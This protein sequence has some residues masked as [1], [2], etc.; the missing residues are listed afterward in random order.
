M[1][2]RADFNVPIK[3][4]RVIDDYKIQRGLPTIQYLIQKGAKVILVSHLGRPLSFPKGTQELSLK[5]VRKQLEKLLEK[6]VALEKIGRSG[7]LKIIEQKTARMQEGDVLMLENIRFL[8]GEEKNDQKLAK[9]LSSLADLFVLDGFAV[10]HRQAASVTGVAK[11]LP[12]YAGLLLAEEIRVLTK[13]LTKPKRPLTVILGGAKVE[14]KIPILKNLL[15]VADHI[16]IGGALASTYLW[17]KGFATGD[18]LVGREF[19][20]EILRYCSARKIIV[21]VDVVIGQADGKEAQIVS[22]DSKSDLAYRQAGIRHRRQRDPASGR[23]NIGIYDIGPATARL[24]AKHIKQAQTL[25]WNGALGMF[26][27]EPYQYGTYAIADLFAGRSKGR[28]LGI[29]GGGETIEIL[30]G[31]GIINEVDLVST[32]GGAMLEFLSGKKL[33]GVEALKNNNFN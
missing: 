5:P 14:T 25:I 8:S 21:P 16:L 20:K 32:G 11:F 2:V 3:A 22:I 18:S 26:E 10:T 15:K 6:K 30:K 31:R 17:A 19:K 13:A 9:Q 29:A 12:S 24:Y 7:E 4:G 28:A 33:P 23:E 1:L 27:R